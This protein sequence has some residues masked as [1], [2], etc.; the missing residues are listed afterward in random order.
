MKSCALAFYGG[1]SGEHEVSAIAPPRS[2]KISIARATSR[3]RS[4]SRKTA[5]G[6]SPIARPSR[7]RPLTSS[8]RESAATSRFPTRRPCGAAPAAA[9]RVDDADSPIGRRRKRPQ[10]TGLSLDVV[11][12]VLHGSH[13]EGRH[14]RACSRWP[15]FPTSA[16]RPGPPP[17][18]WTR[19]SQVAFPRRD[20]AS[21]T[22]WWWR[23][24]PPIRRASRPAFGSGCAF[25]C[26]ARRILDR[27][28]AHLKVPHGRRRLAAGDGPGRR[29]RPQNRRGSRGPRGARD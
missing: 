8:S 15:T 7:R 27:A 18:G 28:M 6:S 9:P 17:W 24:G 10:I 13:G 2:S 1:R 29:V 21:S 11:L 20:S 16:P 23:S 4:A 12:P 5:G 22:G 19:R 14:V 26:S 3:S 25:R